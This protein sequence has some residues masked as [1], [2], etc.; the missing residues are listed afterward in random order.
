MN[1]AER[2]VY[3]G[4]GKIEHNQRWRPSLGRLSC[5]IA[6]YVARHTPKQNLAGS[7]RLR[8]WVLK[9]RI[10]DQGSLGVSEYS[11]CEI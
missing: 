10:E 3:V 4:D 9:T 8:S 7:A 5:R 1:N 6:S 2:Q 11:R